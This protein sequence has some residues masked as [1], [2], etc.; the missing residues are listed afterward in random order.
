MLFG[1]DIKPVISRNRN[2]IDESTGVPIILEQ[3]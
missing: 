2:R 3:N 1:N